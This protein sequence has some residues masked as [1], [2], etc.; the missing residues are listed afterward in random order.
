M[1]ASVLT[2]GALLVIVAVIAVPLAA[3][4]EIV[5]DELTAPQGALADAARR[6]NGRAAAR[7]VSGDR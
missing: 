4:L 1:L 3:G 7:V 6:R 2:F 5:V